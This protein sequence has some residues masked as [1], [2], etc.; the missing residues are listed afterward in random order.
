M[1]EAPTAPLRTRVEFPEFLDLIGQQRLACCD[2][3]LFRRFAGN[4]LLGLLSGPA[5]EPRKGSSMWS[6][7]QKLSQQHCRSGQARKGYSSHTFL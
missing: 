2:D 7:L 3:E 6:K 5:G 1:N 4:Y